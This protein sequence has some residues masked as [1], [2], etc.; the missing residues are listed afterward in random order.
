MLSSSFISIW[1]TNTAK[2][3]LCDPA[4]GAASAPNYS[5]IFGK[6]MDIAM[7]VSLGAVDESGASA[8]DIQAVT[9]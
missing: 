8:I 5:F 3:V 9:V 4:I 2:S 7:N 6:R 1:S